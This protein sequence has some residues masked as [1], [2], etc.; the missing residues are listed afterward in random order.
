[1]N[2]D[3]KKSGKM[4]ALFCLILLI[5]VWSGYPAMLL[6]HKPANTQQ[7]YVSGWQQGC[8]SGT[9]ANAPLRALISERPFVQNAEEYAK[10]AKSHELY[11]NGWN[12][13]Y[14]S[15]RFNQGAWYGLAGTL[16]IVLTLL[17]TR[18]RCGKNA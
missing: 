2:S 16:I 5:L 7:D 17:C 9:T 15:C 18:C 8:Q 12:E 6:A 14:T 3:C 11:K 1:M 4:A 10:D 13:G